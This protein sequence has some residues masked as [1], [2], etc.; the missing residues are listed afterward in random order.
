MYIDTPDRL[1]G[2]LMEYNNTHVMVFNS[3]DRLLK[4]GLITHDTSLP[5]ELAARYHFY[6]FKPPK[7]V[8]LPNTAHFQCFAAGRPNRR[9][10]ARSW[11]VSPGEDLPVEVREKYKG[12]VWAPYLGLLNDTDGMFE[13]R[14]GKG[15]RGSIR[16][17]YVNRPDEVFELDHVDNVE[18]D[19]WAPD[20]PAPWNHP[21]VSM[22]YDEFPSREIKVHNSACARFALCVRDVVDN[23]VYDEK[24]HGSTKTCSLLVSSPYGVIRSLYRVEM[25]CW[26]QHAIRS[27]QRSRKL[28]IENPGSTLYTKFTASDVVPIEAPLPTEVVDDGHDVEVTTKFV[29]E[30][31]H[32]EKE[33][34]RGLSDWEERMEGVQTNVFFYNVYLG[35]VRIPSDLVIVIIKLVENLRMDCYERMKT[36]PI[37][38]IVKVRQLKNF[39]EMCMKHPDNELYV[40]QSIVDVE[41][42]E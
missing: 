26:Y 17:L 31:D 32:F 24:R 28:L 41:Y 14:F 35:K 38:V 18:Y 34:S 19:F 22:Y 23:V 25:G 40:V 11:A 3:K 29:F 39:V 20:R 36:D 13:R 5:L 16:V 37:S 4:R 30:H 15:G 8:E 12:K 42:V 10:F 7:R 9:V 33:W 1:T 21:T 27:A 6:H 2:Y